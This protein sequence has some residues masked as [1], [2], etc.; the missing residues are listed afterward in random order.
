MHAFERHFQRKPV[1]PTM[2]DVDHVL[3]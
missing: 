3:R 1:F 2:L